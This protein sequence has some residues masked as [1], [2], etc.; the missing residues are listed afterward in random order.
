MVDYRVF[1][2][3]WAAAVVAQCVPDPTNPNVPPALLAAVAAV[4]LAASVWRLSVRVTPRSRAQ[5][6]LAPNATTPQRQRMISDV[7]L[8]VN[9][10]PFHAVP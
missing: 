5:Y 8:R 9:S 10:M 6:L 7:R 4:S 2:C 1:Y 3:V